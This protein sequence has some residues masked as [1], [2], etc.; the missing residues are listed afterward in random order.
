MAAFLIL[1]MQ[2]GF[3]LLGGLVSSKNMLSYMTHCFMATT[4]GAFIFWLFGFALMFGGS[5][6][7]PDSI[8]AIHSLV[9]VASCSLEK[10]T[11]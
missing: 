11:M 7:G 5:E 8:K 10:P 4:A 3:V 6:L 1:F 2:A 9:I